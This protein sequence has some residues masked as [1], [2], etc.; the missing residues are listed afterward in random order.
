MSVKFPYLMFSCY[1]K[2]NFKINV[3]SGFANIIILFLK[4]YVTHSSLTKT[5]NLTLTR[6]GINYI[7]LTVRYA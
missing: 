6:Y 2:F 7:K 1:P 3:Q 5:F 4:P